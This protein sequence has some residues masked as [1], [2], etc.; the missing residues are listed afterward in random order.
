VLAV[1]FVAI[2]RY[3]LRIPLRPFFAVTGTL[4]T[5][6]AVSFAGQ[7]VAELQAA[8]WVPATPLNLPALPALGV[9]PTVQTL[10]AQV[11]VAGAFLA[12][13]AWIFWLSPRPAYRRL[14]P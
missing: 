1:V 5:V 13:L 3:G 8:G 4:L 9:F 14:R 12:A 10:A 11:V 2:L 7:G 6:M